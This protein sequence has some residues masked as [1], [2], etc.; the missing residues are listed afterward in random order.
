MRTMPALLA[1]TLLLW[2]A[3]PRSARAGEAWEEPQTEAE[4]KGD[5]DADEGKAAALPPGAE[6]AGPWQSYPIR[7]IERPTVLPRGVREVTGQLVFGISKGQTFGDAVAL[8]IDGSWGL[9]RKL[10]VGAGATLIVFP[11]GNTFRAL[12]LHA[13]YEARG[14]WALRADLEL[15]HAP[16]DTQVG[17]GLAAPLKLRLSGA[18]AL[19]A[20]DRLLTLYSSPSAQLAELPATLIAQAMQRLAIGLRAS[21]ELPDFDPDLRRVPVRLFGQWTLGRRLD[22][23]VGVGLLDVSANATGAFDGRAVDLFV[24]G[25]F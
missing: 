10:D 20:F 8:I 5:S 7:E 15:V 1:A 13:Q 16:G 3:G 21:F 11:E 17:L 25:R 22:A 6:V 12:D 14:P 18:F 19:V 24:A 4:A 23:G 9:R 2:T